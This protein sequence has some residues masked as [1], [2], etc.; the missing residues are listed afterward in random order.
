MALNYPNK[1]PLREKVVNKANL[2]MGLENL[3]NQSNEYY[4]AN[5][6]AVIHKKPTPVQI[7]KV[8]YPERN[9]AKIVEAYYKIPSTTDYNGIY[10]GKYI[11]F[12][13]KECHNKTS[14]P[15]RNIH[16]HQITHLNNVIKHGGIGFLIICFNLYNEYY[17]VK[18]DIINEYWDNAFINDERKSIP[19]KVIKEKGYPIKEAYLPKL[20]YLDSVDQAFFNEEA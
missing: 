13:A 7:V 1:R 6:R 9:K 2:G 12:D 4:L 16:P 5:D 20:N 15:I 19:Y 8:D 14:F 3:I 18:M 10:R 11:D 17:L